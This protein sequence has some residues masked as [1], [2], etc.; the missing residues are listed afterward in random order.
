MISAVILT[1][2]EEKNIEECLRGLS[3]CDEKIVIDDNSTDKTVE[4][5]KKMGAKVYTHAVKNDFSQQ[6][7]FGLEKAKED[8]VLFVDADE[9]VS[10]ALWYEI[11]ARINEPIENFAGFFLKRKDS[12]WGKE[13]EHGEVG[14]IQLLRLARREAGKWEGRIHE[15]WKVKGKTDTLKNPLFHYPHQTIAEF[16]QEIN[17]YTDVRAYELYENKVTVNWFYILLYPKAKF[18]V[19]YFF[20]AGFLDGIPG[21]VLALMMS[22]HSFLVRGKLWIL[23]QRTPGN[24]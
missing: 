2:N 19:N 24:S 20:K 22:F 5:A 6:R 10:S 11:V 8:W 3:W 23:W 7:N 1:K 12:I 15:T 13:L 17:Q 21:L 4:I 18:I 14:N 16:L 9:R